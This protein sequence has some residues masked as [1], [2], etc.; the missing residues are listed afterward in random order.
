[1]NTGTSVIILVVGIIALL[2]FCI[3]GI[4]NILINSKNR[5]NDK[6]EE[7]NKQLDNKIKILSK[8]TEITKDYITPEESNELLETKN[9]LVN[10]ISINDKIIANNKLNEILETINNK[11]DEKLLTDSK[12]IEIK[13]S[14][15]EIDDKINYA[16]EFYN[17][18]AE[19]HNKLIKKVPIMLIAMLFKFK[20]YIIFEQ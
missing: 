1:M 8:I 16:K 2:I 3:I 20:S 13:E 9:K 12:Y 14:I 10:A 18:E 15:K 17:E 7:I 5:V 11:N 19:K 6:W 4:Y